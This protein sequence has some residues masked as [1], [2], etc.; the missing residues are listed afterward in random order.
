MIKEA[1]SDDVRVT[2][3]D[4]DDHSGGVVASHLREAWQ[5]PTAP[6][7]LSDGFAGLLEPDNGSS[8]LDHVLSDVDNHGTASL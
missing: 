8:E 1:L 2:V 3:V 5:L 6:R 4:A 7:W